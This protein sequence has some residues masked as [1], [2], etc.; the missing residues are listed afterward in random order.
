MSALTKTQRLERISQPL[1]VCSLVLFL[2]TSC[3]REE[4]VIEYSMDVYVAPCHAEDFDEALADI[5]DDTSPLDEPY[6]IVALTMGGESC[7]GV[8]LDGYGLPTIAHWTSTAGPT[9]ASVNPHVSS[10]SPDEYQQRGA[11][12][13]Y[14]AGAIPTATVVICGREPVEGELTVIGRGAADFADGREEVTFRGSASGRGRTITA[15]QLEADRPLPSAIDLGVLSVDWSLEPAGSDEAVL[16]ETVTPLYVLHRHP[17]DREPLMH[18]PLQLGCEAAAGAGDDRRVVDAVWERFATRE[19]RRARD[20][21]ALEYYGR[22]NPA[23]SWLRGLLLSGGGQCTTWAH[24]MHATLGAQGIES[25]VMGVFPCSSR[26]RI[27]VGQWA[28]VDGSQL[29]TTGA[30]GVCDTA[31]SNDDEQVVDLGHGRPFTEAIRA[32]I[33]R[34]GTLAGDDLAGPQVPPGAGENGLVET[35][36]SNHGGRF[37][38][39]IP[40][41]FGLP[42]QRAYHIIGD[43]NDIVV[44]GDDLVR[45]RAD[46]WFVLTG[47]DGINQTAPQPGLEDSGPGVFPIPV[48]QGGTS[49]QFPIAMPYRR[50]TLPE[51]PAEPFPSGDDRIHDETWVDTGPDGICDTDA[52]SPD[53]QVV[54]VGQGAPDVPCVGPGA[55]GEL[56]SVP[57][58]DD[59]IVDISD[60]L[61]FA[62]DGF[63]FVDGVNLWP[64]EGSRGQSTD[65]P[66]P[67]FPNHIILSVDGRLY[68]PSYGTGP[69]ADHEAWEAASLAACA[70]IVRDEEGEWLGLAATTDGA[71]SRSYSILPPN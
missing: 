41:D 32:S 7:F 10:E 58:G 5:C 43:P 9:L 6:R 11:P 30:D 20:G 12:V 2:C 25:D 34:V 19:V 36:I 50:L 63:R 4:N 16:G 40:L 28:A 46:N 24:L 23:A 51:E 42:Q 61:L 62:E 66:P 29:I 27:F 35:P 71:L 53:S 31:A 55:N 37:V 39:T 18:T 52:R 22:F 48:G 8:E 60:V 68:D 54:P 17:L 59:G 21:R 57:T 45:Q 13:A 33:P 3:N 14:V 65:M 47:V 38:P 67:D 69:F 70:Q 44:G 56:E 15:F 26:G 1:S 49:I 64:L